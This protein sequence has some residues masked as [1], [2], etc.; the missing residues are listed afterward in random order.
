M[1]DEL[2]KM[3]EEMKNLKPSNA[4]RKRGMD[5]AMAAFDAEFETVHE[6]A[7]QTAND[8]KNIE[9]NQGSTSAAR[10]TGQNTLTGSVQTFRSAAM[11]KFNKVFSFPPKAMMLAGSSVAALMFAMVMM[12]NGME[13]PS[14]PKRIDNI[15]VDVD[16]AKT[17]ASG[18]TPPDGTRLSDGSV[19]I[20]GRAVKPGEDSVMHAVQPSPKS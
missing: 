4:S 6:T 8:Q 16:A 7:A 1:T 12:P 19:M 11:A 17:D 10:P 15:S 3:G 5:A 2:D 18:Q 14:E 13:K 20:N 9:A